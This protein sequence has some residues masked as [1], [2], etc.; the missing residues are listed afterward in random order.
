MNTGH[1][2]IT[3]QSG[4][5]T[6]IAASTSKNVEY[7]LEGSVFVAGAGIQWLRDS[8][9]MLKT[10]AQSQEYAEH[11]PDTAGVY[12]VPA[13]AGMGAPSWDQYARGTIVGITS[14]C[15]KEHFIRATLESI[16]YQTADVLEAMEKD[17]GIDLKSLKV[18]GGASAND[19]L[20]QFQADIV[21]TQVRRPACIETTALGAAYLAGLAVGYWKNRDEIRENWQIGAAFA[22]QME[23]T[24]RRQLLKGWHRAV[25]CALAWAE[26]EV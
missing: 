16:A 2:A 10:S 15:T 25:K 17:S 24:Q 22:P 18:D 8:M 9:R 26:D 3:S 21:N 4:L 1:E 20:M 5:L 23:E 14:G 6:T 19:F 13:F 11:V 7:A 12:I